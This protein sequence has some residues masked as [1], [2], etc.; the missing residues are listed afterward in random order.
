M[1]VCLTPSSLSRLLPSQDARCCK[2]CLLVCLF[3]QDARNGFC[4]HCLFNQY[5]GILIG[6]FLP[7]SQ[8]ARC[9]CCND[10]RGESF[11]AGIPTSNIL[12]L[13]WLRFQASFLFTNFS[14]R[15][16][17]VQPGNDLNFDILM[18][19]LFFWS[20]I[21]TYSNTIIDT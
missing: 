14:L 21:I 12:D 15:S 2:D 18:C 8:D 1:I 5:T 10:A 6:S 4:N 11:M 17:L 19:N 20:K 3:D 9:R 16:Q 13:E 7:S